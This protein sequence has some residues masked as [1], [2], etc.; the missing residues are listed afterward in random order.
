MRPLSKRQIKTGV[1]TDAPDADLAADPGD[2]AA[3]PAPDPGPADEAER[4]SGPEAAEPT[5]PAAPPPEAAAAPAEGAP[6]PPA[7][8]PPPS[9][10]APAPAE[11][12]LPLEERVRRLEEAMA[13]LQEARMR[14]SRPQAA[15]AD[16]PA[17]AP[18]PPAAIPV[19]AVTAA[20]P[21]A[22]PVAA[23]APA[24]RP[25]PT[26]FGV[27][28]AAQARPPVV[29]RQPWL[30]WELIA[31]SRII[32]RMYVDPRYSMTWVAR[33]LPLGMLIVIAFSPWVIPGAAIP[34]FGIVLQ[35]LGELVAGFVLF[36]VLFREARRYRERSPD[37]PSDLRL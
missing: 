26:P 5:P 33:L 6:A 20:A 35:R 13:A 19:G 18:A 23:P 14:E 37:L 31:E 15:P 30:I 4:P 36:K 32:L 21:V 24:P 29:D 25:H 1:A 12:A 22:I 17:A 7:P 27:P 16:A 3:A 11:A 10:P 34:G 28:A 9:V 8:E 2:P